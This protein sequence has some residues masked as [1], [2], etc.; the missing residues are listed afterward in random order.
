M[1]IYV[2]KGCL[3]MYVDDTLY[4]VN[5]EDILLIPHDTFYRPVGKSG[6]CYYF[7]HFLAGNDADFSNSLRNNREPDEKI[8]S[9]YILSRTADEVFLDIPV[10]TKNC[11]T[12]SIREIINK[13]SNCKTWRGK[14]TKLIID[15]YLREILIQISINSAKVPIPNKHL[16]E[17]QVYIDDNFSSEITLGTLSEHFKLSESYIAR[18]FLK[19]LSIRPSEY[20]NRVRTAHSCSLLLSTD[21]GISDISEKCGYSSPYYFSRVFKNIYGISPLA[22]RHMKP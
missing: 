1:L 9:N 22:F 4:T 11:Y 17:I 14:Y 10:Y 2:M 15:N 6:C 16:R 5:A 19:N 21:L 7:L 18:L 13:I 8:N 3:E 12:F 20:V